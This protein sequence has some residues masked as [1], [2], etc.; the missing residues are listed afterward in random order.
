MPDVRSYFI[1]CCAVLCVHFYY[2]SGHYKLKTFDSK[3][4]HKRHTPDATTSRDQPA[5]YLSIHLLNNL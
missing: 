1:I 5:T 4:K 2:E 3:H